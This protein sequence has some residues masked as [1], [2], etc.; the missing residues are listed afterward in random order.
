M[1]RGIVFTLGDVY[2]RLGDMHKT[3]KAIL[4][5]LE[6]LNGSNSDKN[7]TSKFSATYRG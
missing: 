4:A 7:K 3:Q 6:K 5:E 2:R 1:D